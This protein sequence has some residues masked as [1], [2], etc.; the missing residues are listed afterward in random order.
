MSKKATAWYLHKISFTG[1][2]STLSKFVDK[3]SNSFSE[4]K[5][6]LEKYT[7]FDTVFYIPPDLIFHPDAKNDP[8]LKSKLDKDLQM[9]YLKI[10]DYKGKDFSIKLD[11]RE[12]G[13]ALFTVVTVENLMPY[14]LI[15]I[16]EIYKDLQIFYQGE[17]YIND[18]LP[19]SLE[20]TKP[21]CY[22]LINNGICTV[23]HKV[24]QE[25]LIWN[26]STINWRKEKQLKFDKNCYLFLEDSK[27]VRGGEVWRKRLDFTGTIF[28]KTHN[29][30]LKKISTF[31]KVDQGD[32]FF[33][34]KLQVVKS[35]DGQVSTI[36]SGILIKKERIE[37]SILVELVKNKKIK[38]NFCNPNLQTMIEEMKSEL[39]RFK[40]SPESII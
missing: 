16:H 30:I 1:P 10:W 39:E 34:I 6:T 35:E 29:Q 8:K 40:K 28:A 36:Y 5:L 13:L 33:Q 2:E 23:M 15:E 9:W 26:A 38:I 32:W 17:I 37:R 21:N 22:Y 20:I 7:L 31:L 14:A 24:N 19:K 12:P 27:Y 3:F 11:K 25:W 18:K 4:E